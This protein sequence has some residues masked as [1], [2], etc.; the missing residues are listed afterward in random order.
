MCHMCTVHCSLHESTTAMLI[1]FIPPSNALFLWHERHRNY[2]IKTQFM[3]I[4]Q[5][6]N[7]LYV[8]YVHILVLEFAN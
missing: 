1:N 2:S 3:K 7:T 4:L 8:V 5:V 6:M